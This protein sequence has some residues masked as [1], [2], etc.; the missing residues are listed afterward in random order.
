MM[1]LRPRT[2]KPMH[3]KSPRRAG[4]QAPR[5]RRL[6]RAAAGTDGAQLL[7]F[8]LVLPFL[9]VFLIGIIEFGGAFTLK[10]KMANAAR[11]G[12][13]IAISNSLSD[14]TCTSSTPCTIQATAN[15]VEQYMTNN[16][17]N[18]SCIAP[19][20]MSVV[21]YETW[22]YSCPNGTSLTINRAYMYTPAGGG[23]PIQGTQVTLTYPYSWVFNNIIKLLVPGANP[24]LPTTLTETAVMKNLVSS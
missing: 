2:R 10:Q 19:S 8:A 16:G 23:T 14:I 11:E 12:A 20:G 6:L 4:S 15:A 5:K 18:A 21:G 7:E 24:S 3:M 22:T 9:L 1:K 13:R 17:A